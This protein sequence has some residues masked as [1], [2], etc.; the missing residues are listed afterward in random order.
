MFKSNLVTLT[1]GTIVVALACQAQADPVSFLGTGQTSDVTIYHNGSNMTVRAGEILVDGA[2]VGYRRVDGELRPVRRLADARAEAR[3]G[4]VFQQFNLFEHLTAIE[5][6]IE[7]PIHVY[8]MSPAEARELGMQLL[9]SVGLAA[10]ADHMPHRL[11]GG[12]QQRVA[13]AR[14][15]AISPKLMLFDEPTSALD[16]ELV[17][18]VLGVIRQL[19]EAGMTMLVVTHEIAFARDVADRVVFIDEG[20]IIEQGNPGDMIG[21]PKN[22]RTRRFLRI[23]TSEPGVN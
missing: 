20:E 15:L 7:A 17:S 12:Q 5:N 11:S 10:H 14:A 23:V 16:P 6:V 13:I 1:V 8:G 19:A 22:E 4:M 21:N 9:T 3:I 2:L 18:E